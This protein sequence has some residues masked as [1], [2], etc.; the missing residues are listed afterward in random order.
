MPLIVRAPALR[1]SP[2]RPGS[3]TLGAVMRNY[4]SGKEAGTDL[5]ELIVWPSSQEMERAK[6]LIAEHGGDDRMIP[7]TVPVYM[8]EGLPADS[9]SGDQTGDAD[10]DA[11]T[12]VYFRLEDL[13]QTVKAHAER[14]KAAVEAGEEPPKLRMRIGRLHEVAAIRQQLTGATGARVARPR[15]TALLCCSYRFTLRMR[16]AARCQSEHSRHRSLAPPL[17]LAPRRQD[18]LR[19][20]G[21]GGE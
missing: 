1:A 19:P 18:E 14:L 5:E 8:L 6:K 20:I 12:M 16:I 17:R 13:Q 2:L 11:G 15:A 3:T 9:A 4:Q 10:A 7:N 21:A